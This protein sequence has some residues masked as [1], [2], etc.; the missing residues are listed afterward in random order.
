[1]RFAAPPRP[2][3]LCRYR[4]FRR[5]P[6]R[7]AGAGNGACRRGGRPFAD[8]AGAAARRAA[9][10]RG[11]ERLD[12]GHREEVFHERGCGAGGAASRAR[13]PDRQAEGTVR[14][15]TEQLIRTLVSDNSQRARPVSYVLMLAL[16][17]AAPVALLIFFAELG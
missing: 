1:D 12:Q 17:A 8:A 11:R 16:L 5:N 10:D 7:R 14:M 4:R 6:G 2:P 15:D 9:V 13:E 3:R